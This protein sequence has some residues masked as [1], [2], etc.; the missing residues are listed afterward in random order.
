[1]FNKLNFQA[2]YCIKIRKVKKSAIN[3]EFLKMVHNYRTYYYEKF[4]LLLRKIGLFED[5]LA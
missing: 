2:L 3:T 1:M 5:A 4:K